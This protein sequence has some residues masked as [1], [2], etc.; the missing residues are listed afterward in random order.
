MRGEPGDLGEAAE[1]V[2]E[3]RAR[4][5][6][7]ERRLHVGAERDAPDG[8][9]AGHVLGRPLALGE[10]QHVRR[11]RDIV[12]RRAR[13]RRRAPDRVLVQRDLACRRA[14]T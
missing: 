12:Q 10:R 13:R 1:H 3:V 2:V 11:R 7:G 4:L 5:E 8:R 9:R 14:P 6:L